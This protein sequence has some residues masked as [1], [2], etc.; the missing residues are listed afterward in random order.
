MSSTTLCRCHI[1]SSLLAALGLT[2]ESRRSSV[3]IP[4]YVSFYFFAFLTLLMCFLL[5]MTYVFDQQ[6]KPSHNEVPN[7]GLPS[8]GPFFS[9]KPRRQ[10]QGLEMRCRLLC[11]YVLNC[12]N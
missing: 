3:S 7:D 8:F 4:G 12:Y 2:G 10:R 6:R 1:P 11:K 5:D 9:N